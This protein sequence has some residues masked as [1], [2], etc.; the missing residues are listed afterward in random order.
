PYNLGLT[1]GA[2]E[3]VR[4]P[5]PGWIIP[6]PWCRSMRFRRPLER[7]VLVVLVVGIG[8][9]AGRR[10]RRLPAAGGAVQRLDPESPDLRRRF[11]VAVPVGP[12]PGREGALDEDLPSLLDV[13]LAENGLVA[14]GDDPV[15][16]RSLL[17]L[18]VLVLPPLVR[19][20][21]EIAD[22]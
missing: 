18:P 21:R 5:K 14:P 15:P 22:G 7:D 16:L 3:A 10:G 2:C 11:L 20:E 19:R 4:L 9:L 13:F 1:P 17:R 6:A 12:L 8:L